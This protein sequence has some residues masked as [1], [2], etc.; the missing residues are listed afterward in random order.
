M[1][2]D[3]KNLSATLYAAGDL[4][5]VNDALFLQKVQMIDVIY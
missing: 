4:R 1:T 5:M 3:T 2:V